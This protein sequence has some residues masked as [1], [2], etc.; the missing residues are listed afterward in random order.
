MNNKKYNFENL[1]NYDGILTNIQLNIINKIKSKNL[2]VLSDYYTS[3]SQF[4]E[5]STSDNRISFDENYKDN[6]DYI[7]VYTSMILA[8][9]NKSKNIYGYIK[10]EYVKNYNDYYVFTPGAAGHEGEGLALGENLFRAIV[11]NRSGV[12][13]SVEP[14]EA[15]FKR[16]RRPGNKIDLFG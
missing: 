1:I 16:I 10:K 6:E 9:R 12:A 14:Y 5:V 3:G 4:N 11:S 7:K 8:R 13:F 15:S 2:L